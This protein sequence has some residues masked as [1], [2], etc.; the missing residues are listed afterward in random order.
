MQQH[1]SP[2]RARS[3]ANHNSTSGGIISPITGPAPTTQLPGRYQFPA[4]ESHLVSAAGIPMPRGL[5][6][7][8]LP[9]TPV[10]EYALAVA[11]LSLEPY[12]GVAAEVGPVADTWQGFRVQERGISSGLD[13]GSSLEGTLSDSALESSCTGTITNPALDSSNEAAEGTYKSIVEPHDLQL[14]PVGPRSQTASKQLPVSEQKPLLPPPS[15]GSPTP[16][17]PQHLLTGFDGTLNTTGS[18]TAPPSTDPMAAA[19]STPQ[20]ADNRNSAKSI[21]LRD[22]TPEG[23]SSSG[24]GSDTLP[25]AKQARAA[26]ADSSGSEGEAASPTRQVQHSR[27]RRASQTRNTPYTIGCG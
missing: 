27:A 4:P 22:D 5:L 24:S 15:T 1:P 13:F 19:H 7:P 8:A 17:V 20:L 3:T 10:S 14:F 11:S 12:H 16:T 6:S 25:M 26:E 18:V 9:L 23:S 21:Y 2:L